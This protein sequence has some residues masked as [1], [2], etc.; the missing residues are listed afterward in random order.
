MNKK[1]FIAIMKWHGVKDY[2]L[3]L[4]TMYLIHT[5]DFG[6]VFQCVVPPV[7]VGLT[8]HE[9]PKTTNVIL[10]KP[11]EG[12]ASWSFNERWFV[13]KYEELEQMKLTLRRKVQKLNGML[14]FIVKDDTYTELA[15]AML[16]SRDN[17]LGIE[18]AVREAV[19]GLP[20]TIA[21]QLI[22]LAE[23]ISS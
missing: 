17:A 13:K 11:L 8:I 23:K 1:D 18:K 7:G 5:V 22:K 14:A 10:R 20:D 6:Q 19:D 16:L 15:V 3:A 9:G 2:P 4:S 21:A 12:E